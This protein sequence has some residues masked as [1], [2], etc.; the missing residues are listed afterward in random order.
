M[1]RA[2]QSGRARLSTC[3]CFDD[4]MTLWTLGSV[5]RGSLL[6]HT[7]CPLQALVKSARIKKT[8]ASCYTMAWKGDRRGW[9]DTQPNFARESDTPTR[10]RNFVRFDCRLVDR[11]RT[12]RIRRNSCYDR[13]TLPQSTIRENFLI[14][15]YFST[16]I[17]ERN[18]QKKTL[19]DFLDTPNLTCGNLHNITVII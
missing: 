10:T 14:S 19:P 1:K 3:M 4:D 5:W 2:W 15:L 18:S 13:P 16:A 11:M 7:P 6:V 12:R 9:L 17:V 8:L